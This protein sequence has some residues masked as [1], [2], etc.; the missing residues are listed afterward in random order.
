MNVALLSSFFCRLRGLL[1]GS[2]ARDCSYAVFVPCRDIHTFGMDVPLDVAFADCSGRVLASRR[3]V[4][5]GERMRCVSATVAVERIA[6]S[7]PW[8]EV[9][10][11]IFADIERKGLR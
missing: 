8:F 3:S 10:D 4:G 2:S 5:R 9:G 6:T 11:N 7:A 1:P